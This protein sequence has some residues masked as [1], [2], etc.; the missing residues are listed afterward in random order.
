MSTQYKKLELAA[1]YDHELVEELA[2]AMEE[3]IALDNRKAYLQSLIAE[4]KNLAK[5]IWG[6]AEGELIPHHK[7]E[8][9][10][11]KNIMLHLLSTRRQIPKGIRSEAVK[12]GFDIPT[13]GS[14][15]QLVLEAGEPAD[16]MDDTP[17]DE[18]PF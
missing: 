18:I 11:L 14:R 1:S 12:R 6:T 9:D 10:H 16:E 2:S 4:H 15:T 17:L 8:D 13:K 3:I 5:F 7:L